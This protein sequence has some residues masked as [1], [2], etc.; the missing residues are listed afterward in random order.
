MN[1]QT[2]SHFVFTLYTVQSY[3]LV[4][5]CSTSSWFAVTFCCICQLTAFSNVRFFCFSTL[6]TSLFHFI[7]GLPLPFL[8]SRD[9]VSIRLGHLLSPISI[10]CPYHFNM[11]FPILSRIVC[12]APIFSVIHFHNV[13][14]MHKK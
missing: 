1:R 13:Q 6:F 4:F 12:I 5:Q 11:L 9:Q 8:P 7:S 3:V 2:C 10:T 14:I